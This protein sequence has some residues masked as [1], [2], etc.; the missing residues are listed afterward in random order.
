MNK[1]ERNIEIMYTVIRLKLHRLPV[2]LLIGLGWLALY[3]ASWLVG[4]GR[5]FILFY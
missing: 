5:G 4:L 1:H 3:A 2:Y